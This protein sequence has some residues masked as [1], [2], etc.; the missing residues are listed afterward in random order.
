MP[1]G[2][3]CYMAAW[4]ETCLDGVVF[5]V[6]FEEVTYKFFFELKLHI[7][8]GIFI[9]NS[10]VKICFQKMF[11]LLDGLFECSMSS[12]GAHP[13]YSGILFFKICSEL[14]THSP[15]QEQSTPEYF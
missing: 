13:A 10:H 5:M 7:L 12:F 2:A 1:Y 6:D 8:K 11:F 15:Q 14:T 4:M 3:S 9:H